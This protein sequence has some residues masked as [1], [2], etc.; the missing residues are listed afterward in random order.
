MTLDWNRPEQNFSN[1][2]DASPVPLTDRVA[3]ALAGLDVA[4]R[5]L[6][7]ARMNVEVSLKTEAQ[8]RKDFD[9]SYR[10]YSLLNEEVFAKFNV[11]RDPGAGMKSDA[12]ANSVPRGVR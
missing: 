4:A 12:V 3:N 5:D 2:V 9:D 7:Q 6:H 8:C 10:N 1:E 11:V